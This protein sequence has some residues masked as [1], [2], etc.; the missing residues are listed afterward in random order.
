MEYSNPRSQILVAARQGSNPTAGSVGPQHAEVVHLA[1]EPRRGVLPT[2]TTHGLP[3]AKAVGL[4]VI[5]V[6]SL[7]GL[8]LSQPP[9]KSALQSFALAPPEVELGLD[10]SLDEL[11][12]RRMHQRLRGE[13]VGRKLCVLGGHPSPRC[14]FLRLV[15]IPRISRI[16]ASTLSEEDLPRESPRLG[17]RI[18]HVEVHDFTHLLAGGRS[19]LL[20]R[21][22]EDVVIKAA[23]IV[24]GIQGRTCHFEVVDGRVQ[25]VGLEVLA[26]ARRSEFSPVPSATP[27]LVGIVVEVVVV[28]ERHLRRCRGSS[29]IRLG[30]NDPRN[31]L[32][33]EALA[34]L[35]ADIL[36]VGAKQAQVFRH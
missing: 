24:H 16:G 15:H 13:V 19:Q 11:L 4:S 23:S 27:L 5:C 29:A 17:L 31:L 35:R 9:P 28:E 1:P 25:S 33:F 32:S 22:P 34:Q 18:F 2:A 8:G 26:E 7:E 6:C 20:R 12:P 10:R 3:I 30:R 21:G 36:Q 14:L